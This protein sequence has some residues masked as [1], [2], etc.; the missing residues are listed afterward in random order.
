MEFKSL[1][2]GGL[3]SSSAPAAAC[4]GCGVIVPADVSTAGWAASLHVRLEVD[5]HIGAAIILCA[6]GGG[7]GLGE[8]PSSI[9]VQPLL[10]LFMFA[11]FPQPV[12]RNPAAS[13]VHYPPPRSLCVE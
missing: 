1:Y 12:G 8:L 2:K 10:L 11:H 9:S 5:E 3:G 7:W 6:R 13:L 4:C